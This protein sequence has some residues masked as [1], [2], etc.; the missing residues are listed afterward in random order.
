[1]MAATNVAAEVADR[2]DANKWN[3]SITSPSSMAAADV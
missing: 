1:M 3:A 2:T